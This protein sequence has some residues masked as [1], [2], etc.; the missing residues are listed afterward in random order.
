[1]LVA[2]RDKYV[3]QVPRRQLLFKVGDRVI[4]SNS[5]LGTVVRLDRDEQGEYV[6]VSLDL[7]PKQFAYD[8]W[9][10]EKV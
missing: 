6:V 3:P 10:L 7:L 5:R 4:T 8:P 9:D 1:M 2:Q